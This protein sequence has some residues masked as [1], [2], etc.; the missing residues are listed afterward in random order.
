MVKHTANKWTTLYCPVYFFVNF[1]DRMLYMRHPSK[2]KLVKNVFCPKILH[3]HFFSSLFQIE[4]EH[5]FISARSPWVNSRK[6]KIHKH[7]KAAIIDIK[8]LS[9]KRPLPFKIPTATSNALFQIASGRFHLSP[10]NNGVSRGLSSNWNGGVANSSAGPRD[11]PHQSVDLGFKR[12]QSGVNVNMKT[13]ARPLPIQS[14]PL[15]QLL[16]TSHLL[17]CLWGYAQAQSHKLII[18]KTNPFSS[19]PIE[20]K[21][22][23]RRHTHVNISINV[24][25]Q[26]TW[27]MHYSNKTSLS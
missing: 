21:E 12:H 11:V 7:I 22:R 25:H 13:R 5:L 18:S 3:T 14:Q 6:L 23:Y 20:N 8:L 10:I 24:W 19:L 17:P 15:T 27:I 1:R 9:G 16:N 4:D 26:A 2:W